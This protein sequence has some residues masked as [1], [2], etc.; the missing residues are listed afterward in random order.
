MKSARMLVVGVL[1]GILLATAGSAFGASAWKEVTALLRPDFVVK[2]NGKTADL[3]N[4]PL[5]YDGTTYIPLREAGEL[6]GYDVGYANGTITLKD[7]DASAGG[8]TEEGIDSQDW[9]ALDDTEALGIKAEVGELSGNSIY[10]GL[11]LS[12]NGISVEVPQFRLDTSPGVAVHSLTDGGKITIKY[13]DGKAYL[14]IK[15][16]RELKLVS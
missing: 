6:F 2:I 10:N 16:L 7:R 8:G 9:V 12:G 3:S 5:T 14:S 11:T 4:D 1:A 13:A 15:S